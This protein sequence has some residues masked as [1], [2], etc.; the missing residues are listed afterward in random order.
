MQSGKDIDN[1]NV[2]VDAST[3]A[4]SFFKVHYETCK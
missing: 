2:L 3:R 1:I 4:V